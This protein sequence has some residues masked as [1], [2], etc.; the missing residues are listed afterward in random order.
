MISGEALGQETFAPPYLAPNS[1]AEV[2]SSGVNYAS[3]SSGIFDETGSFYVCELLTGH[4]FPAAGFVSEFLFGLT[5]WKSAARTAN[6][7][8]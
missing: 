2:T 3:G 7:V 1:S 4:Y 8:L 5:D 6:Q